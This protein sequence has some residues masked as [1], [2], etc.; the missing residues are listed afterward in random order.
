[1]G[2]SDEAASA[3]RGIVLINRNVAITL[4]YR[5]REGARAEGKEAARRPSGKC[6][7]T[8]AMRRIEG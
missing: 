6:Y 3:I 5:G 1:M 4:N 7:N 2:S 8:L